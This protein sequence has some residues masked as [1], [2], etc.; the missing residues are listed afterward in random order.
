LGRETIAHFVSQALEARQENSQASAGVYHLRNL[1]LRKPIE[2]GSKVIIAG[3]RNPVSWLPE[4]KGGRITGFLKFASALAD[5]G[6]QIR[7]PGPGTSFDADAALGVVIGKRA[8]RIP[9]SGA[10]AYVAGYTLLADITDRQTFQEECRTNN[11]LLAKNHQSLSPLGP[12]IWIP[13][14]GEIVP[15][16]EVILRLNG[17]VRQQFNLENFS[18]GIEETVSAWSRL[19]LE[20]GDVLGLGAAIARTGP[21]THFK[22]P[23]PVQPGDFLEVESAPIGVL[24]AEIAGSEP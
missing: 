9:A 23:V 14:D 17:Q 5:P 6:A 10:F 7:L 11:N 22:S 3:Y 15:K 24:K 8:E 16:T 4:G 20:P 1:V 18:Y 2:P 19:I 13:G 21:G 12:C